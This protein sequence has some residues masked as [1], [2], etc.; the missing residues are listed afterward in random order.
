MSAWHPSPQPLLR[1][2]QRVLTPVDASN[3]SE[4]EYEKAFAGLHRRSSVCV[5]P[6]FRSPQRVQRRRRGCREHAGLGGGPGGLV[7]CIF[8]LVAVSGGG[9]CRLF[10]G[11]GRFAGATCAAA[12]VAREGPLRRRTFRKGGERE[13]ENWRPWK[14]SCESACRRDAVEGEHEKGRLSLLNLLPPL[15]RYVKTCSTRFPQNRATIDFTQSM[16]SA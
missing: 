15:L 1:C 13:A 4:R 11:C 12:I 7:H 8:S 9:D 2:V 16:L 3:S 10:L 6:L 5:F 14:R